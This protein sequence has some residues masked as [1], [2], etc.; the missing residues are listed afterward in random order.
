MNKY[1]FKVLKNDTVSVYKNKN[2]CCIIENNS[3]L[4]KKNETP[5]KYCER[6]FKND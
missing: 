3:Q 5:L 1:N 2:L 4:L 6:V